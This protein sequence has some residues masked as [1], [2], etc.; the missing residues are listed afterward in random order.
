[1]YVPKLRKEMC[2][3]CGVSFE[4]SVGHRVDFKQLDHKTFG[5]QLEDVR[6]RAISGAIFRA[7]DYNHLSS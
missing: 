7:I 6:L 3:K 1:M 5:K 2:V 4:L